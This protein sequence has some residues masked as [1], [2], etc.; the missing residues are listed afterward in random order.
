MEAK[1]KLYIVLRRLILSA[2]VFIFNAFLLN[3]SPIVEIF[4]PSQIAFNVVSNESVFV[5]EG[6][7]V[8]EVGDYFVSLGQPEGSCK[9][10]ID[11]N[12]IDTMAGANASVQSSL[13]LGGAFSIAEKKDT[14]VRMEC[15]RVVG[16]PVRLR[17]QPYVQTYRTA[18]AIHLIRLFTAFFIPIICVFFVLSILFLLF[19]E[20]TIPV[21][22]GFVFTGVVTSLYLTSLCG[23]GYLFT[24]MRLTLLVHSIL[25]ASFV[26]SYLSWMLGEWRKTKLYSSFTFVSVSV[27]VFTYVYRP[28][29]FF[30][31][32]LIYYHLIPVIIA[33]ACAGVFKKGKGSLSKNFYFVSLC[34]FMFFS[35]IDCLM[36]DLGKGGYFSTA[37]SISLYGLTVWS[38]LKTERVKNIGRKLV[39]SLAAKQLEY[40][41]AEDGLK[42]IGMELSETLGSK[43]WSIYLDSYLMGISAKK[44]REFRR[45]ASYGAKNDEIAIELGPESRYGKKMYDALKVSKPIF[46]VDQTSMLGYVVIPI[47]D[48]CCINVGAI[49]LKKFE[50]SYQETLFDECYDKVVTLALSVLKVHSASSLST[51]RLKEELGIGTHEMFYGAVFADAVGYTQNAQNSSGFTEFFE[52]EYVPTLM[53]FLGK[54]AIVKDVFGDEIFLLVLPKVDEPSS[55]V[56]E[57]TLKTTLDVRRFSLETGAELCRQHGF[58]PVEFRIGANYGFGQVIVGGNSVGL[59]GPVIEAKRCQARARSSEPFITNDLMIV[60]VHGKGFKFVRE[61]YAAKKEIL[62]GYRIVEDDVNVA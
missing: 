29:K 13:T 45:I 8:L 24:S 28:E 62:E 32:Y 37:T 7:S 52:K 47:S 23:L 4:F 57:Q 14:A 30:A 26:L 59:T 16:D 5:T 44:A 49:P 1:Q 2:L 11:N 22:S 3:L 10:L 36:I 38:Y 27:F 18:M 40:S 12:Q 42:Q 55:A 39:S 53:R 35:I 17:H 54:Q 34:S 51:S 6:H 58:K 50:E 46:G 15:V 61:I 43:V 25:K 60:A 20:K 31:S 41:S 56:G 48:K 9:L 33:M 19:F 21:P